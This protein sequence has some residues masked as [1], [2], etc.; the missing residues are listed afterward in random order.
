MKNLSDF[1]VHLKH[2]RTFNI[3]DNVYISDDLL[4]HGLWNI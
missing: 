3:F 2:Q 4:T 1:Q